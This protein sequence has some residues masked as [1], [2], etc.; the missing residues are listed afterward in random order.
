MPTDQ[1]KQLNKRPGIENNK[2]GIRRFNYL[3]KLIDELNKREL[4]TNIYNSINDKIEEINSFTGSDKEVIK[5]L[6]KNTSFII[7]FIEKELKLVLK[8]HY[9]TQWM[10]IGLSAFGIPFGVVFGA[11]LKNMAFIGVGI[12]IGMAMGIAIGTAKDKKALEDG[13]QLDLETEM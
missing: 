13:F 9:R 6:R 4:P 8:N 2:K 3:K 12:P 10:A 1:L 7:K 5:L 11:A